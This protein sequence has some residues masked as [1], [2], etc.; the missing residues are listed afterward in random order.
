MELVR[1][2]VEG[3]LIPAVIC[4]QSPSRLSFIIDGAHRLSAIIAWIRDDYGDGD[5]SIEFFSN[6]IPQEQ[7][8]IAEKTKRLIAKEIG[9][10]KE[11]MAEVENPGSNSKVSSY[12]RALAHSGIQLQWLKKAE[13]EKAEQAFFTINQSA[14]KIDKTELKILNTRYKPNAI[15]ARAIVRKATGHKYWKT[16]SSN[17]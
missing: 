3:D 13:S 15:A 4:W 11:F 10:Y 5:V 14:V 17:G 16:F 9:T 2:F 12:A 8:D 1:A 7:R 6:Q